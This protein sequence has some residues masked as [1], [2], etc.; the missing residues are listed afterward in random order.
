MNTEKNSMYDILH[1]LQQV[2]PT[3]LS[4]KVEVAQTDL[5]EAAEHDV[6]LQVAMTSKIDEKSVTVQNY[7]I[8]I[9]LNEFAGREKRFYN[10]VENSTN[11]II[12][13]ELA[14]FETAMGIV[15][16]YMTGKNGIE[17]LEKYD[18][19][20]SNALYEVWTHQTR[21]RRGINED[22]SIAKA[23]AAK[24]RIA[25]AKRKIMKRL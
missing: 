21:A 12:H 7:R 15:K 6:D 19:D 25:E 22:I 2:S 18:I 5:L 8:D 20:Y 13:R 11:K 10:I 16:K 9:I 4:K 14:L 3:S 1:R 24:V 23:D 17:D